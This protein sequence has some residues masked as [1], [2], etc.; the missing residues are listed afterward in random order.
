MFKFLLSDIDDR[1]AYT[2]M[3]DEIQTIKLDNDYILTVDVENQQSSII[4]ILKKE[5][6]TMSMLTEKREELVKKSNDLVAARTL[7]INNKVAAYKAQ[8]EAS[9]PI[10]AEVSK[11][12]SVI[13]AIDEVIAYE[14]SLTTE[15][16]VETS[17]TETTPASFP[18]T[19]DTTSQ[20]VV[21]TVEIPAGEVVTHTEGR[22]GMAAVEIPERR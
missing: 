10:P 17:A 3:V 12:Q 18:E 20:T 14:A 15:K 19:T 8:L 5:E 2:Q 4:K 22:P 11:I 6:I 21:E 1:P 7:E 16:V 9:M 13:K